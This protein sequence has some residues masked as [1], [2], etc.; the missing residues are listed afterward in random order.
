M[1]AV[2]FL[3]RLPFCGM[4]LQSLGRLQ[5]L[6]LSRKNDIVPFSAGGQGLPG[7]G[8]RDPLLLYSVLPFAR[9]D[10]RRCWPD[11]NRS[12]QCPLQV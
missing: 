6:V 7:K 11:R 5:R 1:G 3:A 10:L 9:H 4:V 2:A 8:W 12:G